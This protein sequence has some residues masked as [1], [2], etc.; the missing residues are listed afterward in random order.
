MS[1]ANNLLLMV[2]SLCLIGASIRMSAAPSAA[3]AFDMTQI[4]LND[5]SFEASNIYEAV[6]LVVMKGIDRDDGIKKLRLKFG[7]MKPRGKEERVLKMQF[8]KVILWDL[9]RYSAEH[10]RMRLTYKENVIILDENWEE[11]LKQ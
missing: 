5:V 8:K 1:R 6:N 7:P 11:I 3:N 2:C 4:E 10:F 9:L